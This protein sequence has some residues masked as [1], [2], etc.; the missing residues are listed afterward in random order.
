VNFFKIVIV[1]AAIDQ[2]LKSNRP[3]VCMTKSKSRAHR[4]PKHIRTIGVTLVVTV[5]LISIIA[6]ISAGPASTRKRLQVEAPQYGL[7]VSRPGNMKQFP[8]ELVPL[9]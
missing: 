1:P 2:R 9:P 6:G 3:A 5:V 4:R 7:H 8:P